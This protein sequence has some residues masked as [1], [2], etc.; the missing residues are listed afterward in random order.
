[1]HSHQHEAICD[2]PPD[3]VFAT[4]T[5]LDRLSEWNSH[6]TAVTACPDHLETDAEWVVQM[7]AMGQTWASRS[8]VLEYKPVER[9]FRYRS[10]T[11]DGNPSWAEWAST[12]TPVGD[13]QSRVVVS[14]EL[15][16]QTFWRRALLARIRARQLRRG[17]L[18][19]SLT[20]LAEASAAARHR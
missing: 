15:H 4:V 14:W 3:A 13:G 5:D 8:T 16:P 12:V 6:V 18:P 1:M 9:H 11:D 7:H 19:H 10:C 20:R 17:E 2:L